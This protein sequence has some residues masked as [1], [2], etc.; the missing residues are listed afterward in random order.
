MKKE[1]LNILIPQWQGGG[2]D[3][4]TYNGAKELK[5]YYLKEVKVSEVEISTSQVSGIK[6]N[7]LGYDDIYT[8]LLSSKRKIEEKRPNSIFTLG[9]GCDADMA[10]IAHL[11]MHYDG[12][13]TLLY[14]DA[15]GDLNTPESSNSKYFYGMPLRTLLGDGDPEIINQFGKTLL[16]EQIVMLGIRELDEPELEC[17]NEKSISVLTIDEIEEHIENVIRLVKRKGNEKLYIHIDLDVLDPSDFPYV[18]VSAAEGLKSN[19]LLNLLK[20]LQEE[21]EIVGLG[22]LEYS[23]SNGKENLVIP[24]IIR[25]GTQL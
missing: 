13:M 9:G 4:S 17:I 24:E 23:P 7:I 5:K 19:T 15:H 11:N 2:Q 18:P 10:S 21:F 8:Q 1:H 22:L 16:P 20:R 12:K 3:L 25:I 6:N 14:F